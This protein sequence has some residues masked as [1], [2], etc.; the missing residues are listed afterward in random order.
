MRFL[1][2]DHGAK[3]TSSFNAVLASG[4]IESVL[5]PYR[6]P[7]ANPFTERWV[8]TVREEC[9]DLLLIISEGHLRRM[10][11]EDIE[12]YNQRRP[13]QGIG[14]RMPV[15]LVPLAQ[16]PP[17]EGARPGRREVLAGIFHNYY[18]DSR[19]AAQ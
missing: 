1:I 14:Q 15:P 6:S 10:L 3:F 2:H 13:H 19:Q 17:I 8:R 7:K 16:E 12:Y 9:L 4:G 18:W 5:T 11:I